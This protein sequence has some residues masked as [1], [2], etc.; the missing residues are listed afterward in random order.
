ME[1]LFVFVLKAIPNTLGCAAFLEPLDLSLNVKHCS[2]NVAYLNVG[3][4]LNVRP[5]ETTAITF[6]SF[7]D[8]TWCIY[9]LGRFRGTFKLSPLRYAMTN[10][11]RLSSPVTSV[12]RIPSGE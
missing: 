9:S 7:T 8:T 3:L 1:G 12:S 10:T 6:I 5:V 2:E 4:N 11:T